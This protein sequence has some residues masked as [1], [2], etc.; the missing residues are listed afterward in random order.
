M[1]ILQVITRGDIGGAQRL[2]WELSVE[3]VER[4]NE[5]RII[6]G[7]GEWLK[8]KATSKHI[9]Y[10]IISSL[11]RTY[12]L[13]KVFKPVTDLLRHVKS[14]TP[15][16]VHLH[17]SHTLI[18][19]PFLRVFT[20]ARIV[21]TVHGLSFLH[22]RHK[23]KRILKPL[24]WLGFQLALPFAH[25]VVAVS[26]SDSGDLKKLFL[27]I[28]PIVIVNQISND[29]VKDIDLKESRKAI[30]GLTNN[31]ISKDNRVLGS[32]GR[33][34]YQKHFDLLIEAFVEVRREIPS[35]K[36]VV[37]GEGE[38]RPKLEKLIERLDLKDSFF[39]VG[40]HPNAVELMGGFDAFVLPSRYEGLPITLLEAQA[41]GIPAIASDVGGNKE[42]IGSE[43]V[44]PAENREELV[45]A[46]ISLFL[47]SKTTPHRSSS[48]SN[49]RMV[50]E[51]L[52]VYRSSNMIT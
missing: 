47:N 15:S 44:F 26:Q 16:V 52:N 22:K 28:R 25:K 18:F 41:I 42:V 21:F 36:I 49:D 8:E 6:A 9:P 7:E 19:L 48:D 30:E 43:N 3:L 14:F 11:K 34:S 51:Y 32:V 17:S 23:E 27:F 35:L 20:K 29:F 38:E 1:K 39:L 12:N 10:L 33:L 46:I 4:G 31:Q 24:F 40:A 45:S 37:V 50:K 5:V 2:L 13:V